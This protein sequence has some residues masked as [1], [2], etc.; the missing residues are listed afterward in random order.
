MNTLIFVFGM[1]FTGS[2]NTLS[3]K[4]GYGT[5]SVGRDGV[6]RLF[7]KPWFL[8][9]GMFLGEASCMLVHI[10][11]KRSQKRVRESQQ[12]LLAGNDDSERPQELSTL[13]AFS[14]CILPTLCDLTG[15]TIS[16]I[17]LLFTSA[18]IYQ[19]LRGAGIIFT[20]L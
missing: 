11:Q 18:S 16:G 4:M 9:A 20:G 13:K 6:S 1:L 10:A 14:L 2:I 19:M 15:T 12:G 7:K 3:K 17:G 8:T 5:Y